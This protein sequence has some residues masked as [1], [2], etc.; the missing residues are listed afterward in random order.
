MCQPIL[1]AYD[2]FVCR[3]VRP[4]QSSRRSNPVASSADAPACPLLGCTQ[5]LHTL[6]R[7]RLS[8]RKHNMNACRCLRCVALLVYN[9]TAA[10]VCQPFLCQLD[11]KVIK[12]P[13]QAQSR[14]HPRTCSRPHSRLHP[15]A[16]LLHTLRRGSEQL[17]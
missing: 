7:R 2:E 17:R 8:R 15:N 11:T 10:Q 12:S 1:L 6:Q 16:A 13:P 4:A 3:P 9:S 5:C 14:R